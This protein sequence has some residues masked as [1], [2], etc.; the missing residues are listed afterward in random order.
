MASFDVEKA[1]QA[2]YSD[3]EIQSYMASKNLTPKFSLGGFASNVGKSALGLGKNI[4]TAIPNL[5]GMGANIVTGKQTLGETGKAIGKG[6][7]ERYGGWDELAR[8]AYFDPVGSL[9]DVSLAGGAVAGA[10]KLGKFG[11]LASTAGKVS[12]VTDP[13]RMVRRASSVLTKPAGQLFAKKSVSGFLDDASSALAKKA[14]RP[15]PS[16]QAEFLQAT[17]M[18]IGDYSTR[19]NLQGSGAVGA[20]KIQPVINSI[21]TQYNTLARSGKAIDPTRFINQL[22][23][24]ASD[25][26]AKDFSAEAQQVAKNILS[27]ADLMESKAI[28]YM[29]RN[30]T[31]S[32]PIDIL[33]ETKASA[34]SKVPAGTMVDPTRMHG[35]KVSGGVGI[36]ELER[37][38]PGTQKLGKAQQAAIAFKEIAEK[39]AGLGKGTQL[40]NLLKPSGTG[41]VLGGVLGGPVGAAVGAGA[42]IV[43]NSPRFLAGASKTLKR[44]ADLT[45]SAKIPSFGKVGQV[46]RGAYSVSKYAR[47][48]SQSTQTQAPKQSKK[49]LQP[50][51][52]YKPTISPV[53]PKIKSTMPTAESFYSEIRKKRGF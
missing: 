50:K 1:R 3:Q 4:V 7:K 14:L 28:E 13:L 36:G 30:N 21:R 6:L 10:A 11:R 19:M 42:S 33:T 26:L 46:S 24:S 40:I 20:S 16:Q 49:V 51:P 18:D 41:A 44:G 32:I 2:G 15:S 47:P 38:A 35:G 34:F 53:A 31:K 27:R 37:L 48:F 52:P 9:A 25:I 17:G 45:R 23:K 5:I 12:R 8:T 39:Q 29:V 43:A 22:R